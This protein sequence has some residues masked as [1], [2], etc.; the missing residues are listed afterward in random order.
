MGVLDF[1]IPVVREVGTFLLERLGN[2]Q[3]I[4]SKAVQ[5]W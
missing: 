3:S 2:A 1:L 4:N 5:T